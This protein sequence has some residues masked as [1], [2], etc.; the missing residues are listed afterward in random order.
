MDQP[1]MTKPYTP[2]SLAAHWECTPRHIR[3][4]IEAEEIP[5]FRLGKLIRIPAAFVDARDRGEEWSSQSQNLNSLSPSSDYTEESTA[6]LGGSQEA[7]VE[8]PFVPRT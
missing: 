1:K 7:P 5:S 4:L 8:L 6:S 2:E 3:K